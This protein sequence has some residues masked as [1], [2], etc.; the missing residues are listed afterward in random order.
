VLKKGDFR[1]FEFMESGKL[2][3]TLK[4][5]KKEEIPN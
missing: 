5:R 2:V 1:A 4:V 3:F